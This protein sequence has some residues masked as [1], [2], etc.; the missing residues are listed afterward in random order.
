MNSLN[1]LPLAP[2]SGDHHTHVHDYRHPLHAG[3]R[4]AYVYFFAAHELKIPGKLLPEVLPSCHPDYPLVQRISAKLPYTWNTAH[5]CGDG[6]PEHPASKAPGAVG[7]FGQ[8]RG[9][10]KVPPNI[11]PRIISAAIG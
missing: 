4:Q 6:L 2:K 1:H 7:G 8:S 3:P 5:Q 11:A 9:I 10:H